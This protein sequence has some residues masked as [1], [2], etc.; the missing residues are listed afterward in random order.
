M[1]VRCGLS[2]LRRNMMAGTSV[3]PP[4]PDSPL[5]S[6]LDHVLEHVH[7]VAKGGDPGGRG[8]LPAHGDLP[9]HEAGAASSVERLDV[10]GEAVA[11]QLVEDRSSLVAPEQLEAALG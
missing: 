4:A 10:E 3:L 7:R 5:Q 8:M 11:S 6:D 2:R 9:H 1:G